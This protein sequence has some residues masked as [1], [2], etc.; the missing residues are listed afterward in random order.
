VLY[1]FGKIGVLV[2]TFSDGIPQQVVEEES[3]ASALIEA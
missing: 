3:I 1:F 2:N